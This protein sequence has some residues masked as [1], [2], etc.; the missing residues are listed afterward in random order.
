MHIGSQ[1]TSPAPF[2]QAI[3]KMLPLVAQ[4]RAMAPDTLQFFD[5]GGGLGICYRHERPPTAAAF[6]RAVIPHLRGLGLKILLEPGRFLVG[7]GGVLVMRVLYVKQTPSKQFIITD[8]AMNDLIRPALYDS[9]HEILPLRGSR[10]RRQRMITAD[11]VGP[12]CESGDFFAQGRR[13]SPA[14]AGE[15]LAIMSAGAYGMVM[16]SN[17]NSRPRPAE[18]LVSG[19]RVALVRSRERV[20]DLMDREKI[21]AWLR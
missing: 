17:Y 10:G 15:L 13:L 7:N 9:Y 12:I 1:I 8:A 21:A 4:V 14:T 19:R 18:V 11:V 2:V 5:I 16:A 20:E 3:K 6:A